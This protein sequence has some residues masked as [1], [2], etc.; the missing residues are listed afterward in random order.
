MVLSLRLLIC[1]AG[2]KTKVLPCQGAQLPSYPAV[3]RILIEVTFLPYVLL[4]SGKGVMISRR[5]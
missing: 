5:I 1:V 2:S 4:Q 3:Q